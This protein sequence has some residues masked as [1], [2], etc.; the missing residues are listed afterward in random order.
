MPKSDGLASLLVTIGAFGL[1]I[2]GSW[3]IGKLVIGLDLMLNLEQDEIDTMPEH[4]D[5]PEEENR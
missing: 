4:G 5:E 2:L 1:L 3:I